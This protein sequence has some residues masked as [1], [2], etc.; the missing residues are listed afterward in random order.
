M[1]TLDID[2]AIKPHM[3]IFAPGT[4]D[5]AT[6]SDEQVIFGVSCSLWKRSSGG[7]CILLDGPEAGAIIGLGKGFPSFSS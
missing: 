3:R 6:G 5:K 7:P 2:N 1:E 4:L